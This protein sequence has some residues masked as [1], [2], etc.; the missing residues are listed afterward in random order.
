MLS[1]TD[2]ACVSIALALDQWY[3]GRNTHAENLVK[4]LMLSEAND[5]KIVVCATRRSIM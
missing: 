5:Y 4:D 3:K 1:D 2:A